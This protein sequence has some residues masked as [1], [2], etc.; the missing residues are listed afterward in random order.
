MTNITLADMVGKTANIGVRSYDVGQ[1]DKTNGTG[2]E[3]YSYDSYDIVGV[4]YAAGMIALQYLDG[5]APHWVHLRDVLTL[6]MF[7]ARQQEETDKE[8]RMLA[9]RATP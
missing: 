6:E 3:D 9:E 1:L 5:D 8:K 2:E 4:D 7:D